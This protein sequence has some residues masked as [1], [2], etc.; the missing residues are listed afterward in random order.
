MNRRLSIVALLIAVTSC[1]PIF[2]QVSNEVKARVAA[3]WADKNAAGQTCLAALDLYSQDPAS[4]TAAA[5]TI[6]EK[7][8]SKP[9][10]LAI[11]NLASAKPDFW[12]LV[13]KAGAEDFKDTTEAAAFDS[14]AARIKA[15]YQSE[16]GP[17]NLSRVAVA[18]DAKNYMRAISL[19]LNATDK[20]LSDWTDEMQLYRACY[21]KRRD[22][23]FA[24][25]KELVK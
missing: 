10:M 21:A 23:L 6:L 25:V 20:N 5:L 11:F 17:A 12:D 4:N 24:I 13:V 22:K 8:E 7:L 19:L 16:Q 18:F 15:I 3:L 14:A 2:G 1:V 9:R